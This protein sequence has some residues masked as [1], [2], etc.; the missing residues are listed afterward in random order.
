MR[1]HARSLVK[2]VR[3][4]VGDPTSGCEVGVWRG[5][6]SMGLLE[7]FRNLHLYAVDPWE[8]GEINPTMASK[9]SELQRAHEE[10]LQLTLP[11]NSRLTTLQMTSL[12]ASSICSDSSLDF[13]F[14]DG[15]HTYDHVS[16]DVRFWQKKV[17]PGGL[18]CGHD[19]D[20]MGDR[21]GLFGVK[22]AVDE[23]ATSND[24]TIQ[25]TGGNIWWV[26]L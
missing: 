11:F 4:I 23:W 2:L 24:L 18:F 3:S 15:V 25:V 7:S 9:K 16:Q 20:G 21:R 14:I 12:I 5:H 13:V 1:R 26:Q 22:R 6:T 10:F 19:Y 17:K 8:L